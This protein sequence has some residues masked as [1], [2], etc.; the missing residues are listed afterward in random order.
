QNQGVMLATIYQYRARRLSHRWH[1]WLDAGSEFWLSKATKY[2][3][4]APL[5]LE[6]WSGFPVGEAEL[7][8]ANRRQ[9]EQMLRDLLG[10]VEER[11]YL[12]HSD[13]SVNGLE[14]TGPLMNLV[15]SA[16]GVE[17]DA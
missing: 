4:G 6:S 9:L 5:F 11:L 8:Q 12:C 10:R 2:L 13:L 7:A 15:Q 16:L 17:V 3:F 14:Q 1:F